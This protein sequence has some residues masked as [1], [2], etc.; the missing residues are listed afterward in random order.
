MSDETSHTPIEAIE[1]LESGAFRVG[2]VMRRLLAE[3]PG[4]PVF[5]FRPSVHVTAWLDDEPAET[6]LALQFSARTVDGVRA[7]AAALDVA[8]AT[9]I[10]NWGVAGN[11]RALSE[12]AEVT[13]TADG[14]QLVI[15]G[16]RALSA[17]EAAAWHA[18]QDQAAEAAP[19][20][21]GQ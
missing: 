1:A 6:T 8:A 5:Y 10:K 11:P 2:Q 4:L 16:T 7:W 17:E 3:H 19:Q 18:E 9:E 20:G 12:S 13:T 21:G 14:V 15:T